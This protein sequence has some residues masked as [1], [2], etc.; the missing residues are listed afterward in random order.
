MFSPEEFLRGQGSFTLAFVGL[1]PAERRAVLRA[2]GD[3]SV[4]T[5][6]ENAPAEAGA[7]FKRQNSELINGD[8]EPG[9][10][11]SVA[12]ANPD[13][14]NWLVT[15]FRYA[16]VVD[17][18]WHEGLKTGEDAIALSSQPDEYTYVMAE[19]FPLGSP[20]PSPPRKQQWPSDGRHVRLNP[21]FPHDS[22]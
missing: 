16:M 15:F 5:R 2:L 13:R 6:S 18:Q 9:E 17:R 21:F 11:A 12:A 8:S 14:L 3:R 20:R 1:D 7:F 19:A 22:E 4:A 10:V